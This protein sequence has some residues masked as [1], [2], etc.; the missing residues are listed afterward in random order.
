MLASGRPGHGESAVHGRRCS[1]HKCE[2]PRPSRATSSP[3]SRNA[4]TLHPFMLSATLSSHPTSPLPPSPSPGTTRWRK[5]PAPPPTSCST[6]MCRQKRVRTA[7]WRL[8]LR[9]STRA[10]LDLKTTLLCCFSHV[11]PAARRRRNAHRA[12]RRRHEAAAGQLKGPFPIKCLCCT[13]AKLCFLP[14]STATPSDVATAAHSMP[15]AFFSRT[16]R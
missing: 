11:R 5:P 15:P 16:R 10:C 7:R 6:A 9:R 3:R 12:Q 8:A 1:A 2:S 4:L 14:C 13:K